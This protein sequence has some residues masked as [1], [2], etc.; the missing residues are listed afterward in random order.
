MSNF[1]NVALAAGVLSA[2][3]L[4][5]ASGILFPDKKEDK[6][7]EA[8]AAVDVVTVPLKYIP[9]VSAVRLSG[10]TEAKHTVVAQARTTGIVVDLPVR[11]GS[12]VT[13]GQTI[14]ELSDEARA[15]SLAQARAT[16]EQARAQ[17]KAG[18]ALAQRGFLS[19]IDLQTRR[20]TLATAEAALQKALS[21]SARGVVAAPVSGVLDKF[22]AQPGQSLAIGDKVAN[23]LDLD[24]LV[25]AGYASE[26]VINAIDVGAAVKVT[27]LNGKTFDAKVTLISRAADS[28]TRTFRIE[29]ETANPD[30][31]IVAGLTSEMLIATPP[32][33]AAKVARSAITLNADG[34]LGVM[35]VDAASHA[36]FAR[37]AIVGDEGD[38]FWVAGPP[39]GAEAIVVGQEFVAP[40]SSVHAVRRDPAQGAGV[41]SV[42][43]VSRRE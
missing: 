27:T 19:A 4:W 31:A 1:T 6:K 30:S 22:I 41:A 23:V 34:D 15:A 17:L 26:R 25:V 39:D 29:A 12:P 9:Y 24:P 42:A 11:E 14:A 32:K 10:R 20:A 13:A 43:S 38:S 2:S 18:E 5:V 3:A 35:F 7:Q 28:A 21:E 8:E 33:P 40:G 36:Q 37:I 16:V